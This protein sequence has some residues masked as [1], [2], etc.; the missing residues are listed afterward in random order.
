MGKV[1][2]YFDYLKVQNDTT[3]VNKTVAFVSVVHP[4]IEAIILGELARMFPEDASKRA[5]FDEAVVTSICFILSN[6]LA[7]LTSRPN[8]F[9][10]N[11][12]NIGEFVNNLIT[13]MLKTMKRKETN[14]TK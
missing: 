7:E 12:E 6:Y 3:T 2:D 1:V 5:S 11:E 4:Q 10:V 13:L 14:D 8:S 9:K